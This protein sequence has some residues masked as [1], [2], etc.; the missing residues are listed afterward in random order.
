MLAEPAKG[1][2]SERV[3]KLGHTFQMQASQAML[4]FVSRGFFLSKRGLRLLVDAVAR[5]KEERERLTRRMS[6]LLKDSVK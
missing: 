1:C 4:L 2:T 6:P 5:E 3:P